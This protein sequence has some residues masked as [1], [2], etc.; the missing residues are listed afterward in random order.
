MNRLL[1]FIL[2]LTTFIIKATAQ[3]NSEYAILHYNTENGLPSNGIKGMEWDNA[4]GFLWIATEAGLVRFNG[5]N[6]K[7]F[8]KK[9]TEF[10]K[11]ERLTFLTKSLNNEI[12]TSD[13][14][15]NVIK[16]K[17]NQLELFKTFDIQSNTRKNNLF[18]LSVSEKLFSKK[19]EFK[20]YKPVFFR[21]EK[22][23]PVDDTSCYIL[24]ETN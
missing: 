23:I 9:N 11:T 24:Q 6:F 19:I 3:E 13:L 14:E 7:I 5:L 8:N 4:N 15:G 10:I 17:K 1:I 20:K 18:A 12:Y 2:L 22:V 21:F 16:V